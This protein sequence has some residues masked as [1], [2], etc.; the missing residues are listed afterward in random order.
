[1]THSGSCDFTDFEAISY[2][3]QNLPELLAVISDEIF[4]QPNCLADGLRI[5]SNFHPF[6]M[7]IT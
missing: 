5:H 7:G 6:F 3:P 1:M 4:G 2:V